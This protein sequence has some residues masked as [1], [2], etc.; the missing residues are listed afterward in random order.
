MKRQSRSR[1]AAQIILKES[2]SLDA[3]GKKCIAVP[4]FVMIAD[5]Q[6]LKTIA[7]QIEGWSEATD[8]DAD[9][10]IHLEDL[11]NIRLSDRLGIRVVLLTQQ[12]RREVF[13]R[14]GVG[15]RLRRMNSLTERY[16]HIVKEATKEIS[17]YE[18]I[19]LD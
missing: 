19:F 3:S 4:E 11:C 14:Y 10:H 12:N 8:D 18:A 1:K 6:G 9:N 13:R 17:K 15:Q 7:H 5:R 16:K 2:F